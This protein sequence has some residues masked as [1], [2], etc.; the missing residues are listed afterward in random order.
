MSRK[1]IGSTVVTPM[2]PQKFGADTK[3]AKEVAKNTENIANK[4]TT[5]ETAEIGQF[6]VVKEIDENGKPT[7]FECITVPNGNEV[8]Y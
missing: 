1:I 2:N 3:L 7:V 5:P 8:M 4:V 6:V